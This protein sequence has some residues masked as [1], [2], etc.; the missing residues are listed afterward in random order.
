MI[1]FIREELKR[2]SG[3]GKRLAPGRRQNG[4][5]CSMT[6]PGLDDMPAVRNTMERFA[7]FQ[8]PD[9]LTGKTFMDIGSNVGAMALEAARRGATTTGLEYRDDRVSL[10]NV[11]ARHYE[12]SN[13]T[14]HVA[15]FNAIVSTREDEDEDHQ[16]GCLGDVELQDFVLCSSVDRYVDDFVGFYRWLRS[17]TGGVCLFESDRQSGS[18]PLDVVMADLMKAGFS[19]DYLGT[20]PCPFLRR[21]IFHLR[22]R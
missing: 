18:V 16:P 12:M 19:V 20:G 11:I 4:L 9:D 1:E 2:T 22:P 14:F 15:D 8:V 13:A 17:L 10:C 6:L 7:A 5:Y 21:K 3:G